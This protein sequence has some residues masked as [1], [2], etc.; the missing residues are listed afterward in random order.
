MIPG[1]T[2]NKLVNILEITRINFD[3]LH[4]PSTAFT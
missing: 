3:W 1:F 4:A 2:N